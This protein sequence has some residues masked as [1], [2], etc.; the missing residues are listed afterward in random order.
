MLS[1]INQLKE[2]HR[3]DQ[4][5]QQNNSL[6]VNI[7]G[8]EELDPKKEENQRSRQTDRLNFEQKKPQMKSL[9]PMR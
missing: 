6:F 2:K 7:T 3:Q 8:I 4:Q 1:V 5:K 9:S